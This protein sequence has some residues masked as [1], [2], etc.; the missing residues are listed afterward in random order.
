LPVRDREIVLWGFADDKTAGDCKVAVKSLTV[1]ETDF[2]GI[3][4]PVEKGVTRIE[5]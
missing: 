1:D 4:P 2:E 5:V 3:V